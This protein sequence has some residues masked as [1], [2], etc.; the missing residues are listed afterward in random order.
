MKRF[1]QARYFLGGLLGLCVL[2]YPT[3]RAL[4]SAVRLSLSA[5]KLL[6]TTQVYAQDFFTPPSK[7]VA[8]NFESEIVQTN[9]AFQEFNQL[10]NKSKILKRLL[11]EHRQEKNF[12]LDLLSLLP[13]LLSGE[14]SY[15]FLFQNSEELRATGGFLGSYATMKLNDG[16]LTEF[17]IQDIYVPDGQYEGY[18]APPAGAK[19][20]LSGGEGLRLRDAN[21]HP[22]FPKS[23][24]QI[25]TYLG[26]GKEQGIDGAIAVNL[27][28]VEEVLKITGPIYLHDS[29]QTITAQNFSDIARVDRDEFFPGSVQ[30][31]HFLKTFFNQLV[32]KLESLSVEEQKKL[33]S[34]LITQAQQ[35]NLQF[36]SQD[37]LFENFFK[38]WGIAGEMSKKNNAAYLL[39]VESNVGINKANQH[40]SRALRIELSP[41]P[42][43]ESAKITLTLVNHNLPLDT[44]AAPDE[45]N[46]LGYVNYQRLF[47][48]PSANVAAITVNQQPLKSWDSEI[49]TNSQGQEF[50]QIGFLTTTKEQTST[51]I[52]VNVENLIPQGTEQIWI[53]KQAGVKAYPLELSTKGKTQTLDLKQDQ[54]LSW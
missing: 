19:E 14:K 41:Q 28:F 45:A 43:K 21:W 32:M 50:K 46:H 40:L 8:F 34:A 15:V 29:Q 1:Y 22:D 54:L 11:A 26:W 27:P 16:Q 6:E 39:V 24:Q 5:K 13:N 35:K 18:I 3:L 23:A 30:K 10:S 17:K 20:Y 12:A 33:A 52:E 37:Q 36:F 7:E 53:Q 51:Q 4:P 42:T 38:K 49:I 9:N 2:F 44:K 25:L 31:Q 48:L 47:F